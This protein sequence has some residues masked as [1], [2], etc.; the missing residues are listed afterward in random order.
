MTA[1]NELTNFDISG[2]NIL[3]REDLNVPV[4]NNQIVNDARIL[5][6]IPTIKYALSKLSKIQSENSD[7][8]S[9]KPL[10]HWDAVSSSLG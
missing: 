2:K 7:L 1:Y 8:N 6:A 3:I 5:A 9:S 4:Y 10:M